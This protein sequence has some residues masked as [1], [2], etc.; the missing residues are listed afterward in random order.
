MQLLLSLGRFVAMGIFGY[1][2][3]KMD[4]GVKLVVGGSVINVAY[5]V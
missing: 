1:I 3:L 4:K 5:P 2:V